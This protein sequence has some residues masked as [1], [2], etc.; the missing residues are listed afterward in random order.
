MLL[1]N[2]SADKKI[3]SRGSFGAMIC[4]EVDQ[5]LKDNNYPGMKVLEFAFGG[6]RKN[7]HLPYNYTNNCVCYGGTHDNETLLGFFN[8]RNDGRVRLCI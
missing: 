7:P 4:R 1:M 8:D 5:I 3:N 6:D 2:Q